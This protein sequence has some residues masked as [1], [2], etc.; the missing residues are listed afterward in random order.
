[1]KP[2]EKEMNTL[3]R[4]EASSLFFF[5]APIRSRSPLLTGSRLISLLLA[6]QMFQ[7]AKFEKFKE[8]RLATE[9]G[10]GFPVRDPW[11]TDGISPWPFASESVLPS[12]CPGHPSN[13]FFSILYPR[14]GNMKDDELEDAVGKRSMF[15]ICRKGGG[16]GWRT[17]IKIVNGLVACFI[18]ER[19]RKKHHQSRDDVLYGI[20]ASGET[21]SD[22]KMIRI[23]SMGRM[24]G[25]RRLGGEKLGCLGGQ[26]MG[27]LGGQDMELLGGGSIG[28]SEGESIGRLRRE[29][30][31]ANAYGFLFKSQQSIHGMITQRP[32]RPENYSRRRNG[33][34]EML[35]SRNTVIPV[36]L[37]GL[38][39]QHPLF[40]CP[41]FWNDNEDSCCTPSAWCGLPSLTRVPK[42]YPLQQAYHPAGYLAHS[43]S[44]SS[45]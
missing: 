15:T 6:T 42:G 33:C 14:I 36:D 11:I 35:R 5:K 44:H 21:N 25:T 23:T 8:R 37:I 39:W 7:F 3:L 9:L 2:G 38:C 43:N 29:A 41:G 16:L 4:N 12:Q 22:M 27:H 24:G 17:I 13:A 34:Q 30:T 32:D 10:Y 26:D 18:M 1:M 20:R 19:T 45:G 40:G 28:R 31:Y